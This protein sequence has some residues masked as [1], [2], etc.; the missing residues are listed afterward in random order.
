MDRERDG[1]V[2][3]RRE[4]GQLNEGVFPERG[5]V[6]YKHVQRIDSI[7]NRPYN[8]AMILVDVTENA[9]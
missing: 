8:G 5:R 6:S 7:V 3:R 1:K 9:D 2:S 4:L